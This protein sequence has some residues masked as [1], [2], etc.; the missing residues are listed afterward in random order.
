MVYHLSPLRTEPNLHILELVLPLAIQGK[1]VGPAGAWQRLF[2]PEKTK[3]F[4]EKELNEK[5]G[6]K[7]NKKAKQETERK[8]MH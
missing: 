5:T 4:N 2:R 6:R 8:Q 3:K 7:I 1:Q